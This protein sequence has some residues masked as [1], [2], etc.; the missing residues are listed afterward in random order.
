MKAI[1]WLFISVFGLAGL[2]VGVVF[3]FQLLVAWSS[4][5]V[6]ID[7]GAGS[8]VMR[9]LF[10]DGPRYF[11]VTAN[12]E[13]EGEPIEITRVMEC[14][15]Y[16]AHRLD[17]YFRQRWYM[18]NEAMTHRLPDGS[19]LIVVI[20]SICGKFASPQPQDAPAW[21]AFPDFPDDFVP[22][23]LWT[24]DAEH[25]EVL[26]GYHSFE[27]LE[28]PEA[29]VIFKNIALR[30]ESSLEPTTYPEEFGFWINAQHGDLF[31]GKRPPR[32]RNYLGYYLT[33]IGEEEWSQVPELKSVLETRQESGF[34][35]HE[36]K[37]LVVGHFSMDS[38]TDQQSIDG[39]LHD[40]R[41]TKQR[42]PF[43]DA[44]INFIDVRQTM[45]GF[46]RVNGYFTPNSRYRGRINYFLRKA[47]QLDALRGVDVK[48]SS[49]GVFF[50]KIIG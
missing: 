19:G 5:G 4:K 9:S 29:R 40:R 3:G 8:W 22:L 45:H 31:G 27:S 30:N 7:G 33:S 20:P 39:S 17:D 34:L 47:G 28:R 14:Q 13:V 16:F 23:I 50:V 43:V 42:R 12:L 41:K 18:S 2:V 32:E 46:E 25:P 49:G 26:E 44:G 11:E 35:E 1:K 21:G 6:G 48:L 36:L 37:S 38:S 15:P 10:H 24:V